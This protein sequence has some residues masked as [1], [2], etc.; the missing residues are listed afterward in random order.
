MTLQTLPSGP[1]RVSNDLLLDA[2][3]SEAELQVL[4]QDMQSSIRE[5][6]R[7]V[8]C[9]DKEPDITKRETNPTHSKI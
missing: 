4:F 8:G 2:G 6:I 1:S 7:S 5:T 3:P 9:P